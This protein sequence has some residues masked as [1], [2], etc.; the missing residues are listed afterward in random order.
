MQIKKKQ[1]IFKIINYKLVVSTLLSIWI[2]FWLRRSKSSI[3]TCTF[4]SSE[5]C[6]SPRQSFLVWLLIK[7][8]GLL[9]SCVI[10]KISTVGLFVWLL[11]LKRWLVNGTTRFDL[12]FRLNFKNSGISLRKFLL[13]FL[14]NFKKMKKFSECLSWNIYS[15]EMKKYKK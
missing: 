3:S 12:L 13:N 7:L 11:L 9:L 6:F 8:Y 2:N 14:F 15:I 1:N 4:D 10:V 5:S